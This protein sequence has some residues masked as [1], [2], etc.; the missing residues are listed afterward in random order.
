MPEFIILNKLLKKINSI[1]HALII[2]KIFIIFF[3]FISGFQSFLIYT[4]KIILRFLLSI[5]IVIVLTG[6]L[7]FF[8]YKIRYKK[9]LSIMLIIIS[10]LLN[11]L[12]SFFTFILSLLILIII[13]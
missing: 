12:F 3:Y 1:F 7:N 8:T 11:I 13:Y 9:K 10:T 5:D 6:I 4:T 2:L